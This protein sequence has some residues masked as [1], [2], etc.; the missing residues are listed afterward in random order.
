[1][2]NYEIVWKCNEWAHYEKLEDKYRKV[3]TS[4]FKQCKNL[5]DLVNRLHTFLSTFFDNG[6][7]P[8]IIS[9]TEV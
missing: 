4:L 6:F 5:V 1:M 8:E 7:Y 2:K 3:Y 9:I